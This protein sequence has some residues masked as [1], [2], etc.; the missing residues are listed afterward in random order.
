MKKAGASK[1]AAVESGNVPEKR[2]EDMT[3]EEQL[4]YSASRLKK[5]GASKD[6]AEAKPAAA[7]EKKLEDVT[8][9]E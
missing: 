3:L 8:L 4:A 1:E 6:T 9:E 2:L 5:A 7:P